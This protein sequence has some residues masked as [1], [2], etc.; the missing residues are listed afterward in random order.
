MIS[1]PYLD[2]FGGNIASGLVYS[3]LR[4]SLSCTLEPWSVCSARRCVSVTQLSQLV[5]NPRFLTDEYERDCD[6]RD[7]LCTVRCSCAALS[8]LQQFCL[9]STCCYPKF[10]RV[11]LSSIRVPIRHGRLCDM[12]TRRSATSP[13]ITIIILKITKAVISLTSSVSGYVHCPWGANSGA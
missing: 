3:E 9:V 5:Y 12:A 8:I 11:D 6:L 1:R 7:D 2:T 4:L 13:A 10:L